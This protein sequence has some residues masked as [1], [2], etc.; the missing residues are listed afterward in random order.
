MCNEGMVAVLGIHLFLGAL[1]WLAGAAQFALAFHQVSR[2]NPDEKIPQFFG[3]PKNHPG[4]IYF[5]RAVAILLLMLSFFAWANVLG[6]WAVLLIL[7]G[8]VPVVILNVR[9]NRQVESPPATAS[10]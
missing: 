1:A 7:I 6:P 8:A 5:Y 4:V 2:A 10:D 3:R 9:H